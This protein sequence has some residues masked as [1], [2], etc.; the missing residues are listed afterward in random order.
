MECVLLAEVGL[1]SVF[2]LKTEHVL[3]SSLWWNKETHPDWGKTSPSELLGRPKR[4]AL[5]PGSVSPYTHT[6]WHTVRSGPQSKAYLASGVDQLRFKTET[7]ENEC[8]QKKCL[9]LGRRFVAFHGNLWLISF[10]FSCRSNRSPLSYRLPSP[11]TI[12]QNTT[13]A[14]RVSC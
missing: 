12:Y 10:L 6:D 2:T 8:R 9:S 4:V 1:A 7:G 14:L 5:T 3:S 11:L 13:Q